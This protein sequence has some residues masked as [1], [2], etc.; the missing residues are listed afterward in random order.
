[1]L[2]NM[3][4]KG[5]GW[6]VGDR[7]LTFPEVAHMNMVVFKHYVVEF[8]DTTVT[9]ARYLD[10]CLSVG[11]WLFRFFNTL[12]IR[13]FDVPHTWSPCTSSPFTINDSTTHLFSDLKGF[14][15]RNVSSKNDAS[16]NNA[17]EVNPR[18]KTHV[19]AY[20]FRRMRTRY[21]TRANTKK[22]KKKCAHVNVIRKM[23]ASL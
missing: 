5:W 19:H 2:R 11:G 8:F 17:R 1:M 13:R 12:Q 4:R 22:G 10:T 21:G 14:L 6:G 20:M 7:M 3:W 18:L 16:K 23:N 9:H 15:G